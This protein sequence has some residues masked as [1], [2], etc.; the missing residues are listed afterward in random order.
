M[1]LSL[2]EFLDLAEVGR[3]STA[4]SNFILGL[5]TD[6]TLCHQ[7]GEICRVSLDQNYQLLH[8]DAEADRNAAGAVVLGSHG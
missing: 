8:L 5:A 4:V 2:N 6:L 3:T 7:N 1:N